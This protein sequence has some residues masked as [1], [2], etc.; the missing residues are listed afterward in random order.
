MPLNAKNLG[1]SI[2]ILWSIMLFLMTVL[3]ILTGYA[4]GLLRIVASLYPGY[5]IS[6]PGAV[7]GLVYG[8][9]DGFICGYLIAWL[10]NRV[11]KGKN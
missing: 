2:G 4:D 1:L 6:W 9:I 10:Y 8:F 11:W 3:S 5:G 7:I